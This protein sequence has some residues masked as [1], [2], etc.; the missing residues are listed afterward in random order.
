[1]NSLHSFCNECYLLR[2]RRMGIKFSKV[3]QKFILS[4]L[5]VLSLTACSQNKTTHSAGSVASIDRVTSEDNVTGN[6][7]SLE[8]F[9]R[10]IYSF[11]VGFG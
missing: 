1:M 6:V 10:S 3:T 4:I 7:D 8:K 9:N 11:N 5:V 2:K